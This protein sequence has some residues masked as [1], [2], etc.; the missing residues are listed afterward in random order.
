VEYLEEI[1]PENPMIGTTPEERARVKSIE[2]Y[3]DSEIMGT[4]G[5]MAQNAMPL[6]ADRFDQHPA[7]VAYGRHR[8]KMA[9]EQLDRL[10]GDNP[11]VA[12][13]SPTIGD[14]TL[15]AIYEFADLVQAPLDERFGNLCRWHDSFSK[16]PSV[17]QE[18]A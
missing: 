14:A 7:C 13:L 10:V 12:G 11:F 15:Y 18:F 9:L 1:F 5:I 8:Q 2:R 6:Y 4:M 3:I 16:R 17:R